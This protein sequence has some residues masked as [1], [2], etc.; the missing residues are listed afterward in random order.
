MLA[1]VMAGTLG[2]PL[3]RAAPDGSA[4]AP[5]APA[6]PLCV[7]V[8]E[9]PRGLTARL[10]RCSNRS[11]SCSCADSLMMAVRTCSATSVAYSHCGAAA[12]NCRTGA[13]ATANTF[14]VMVRTLVRTMLSSCAKYRTASV[15]SGN[16]GR[17]PPF[18]RAPAPPPLACG[19]ASTGGRTSK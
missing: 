4:A 10:C 11:T 3:S 2:A 1:V 6:A 18:R 7:E 17:P 19:L 14:S 5:A 9:V 8:L 16:V 13:S 12:R 15:N